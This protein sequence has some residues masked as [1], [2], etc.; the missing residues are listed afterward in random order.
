MWLHFTLLIMTS[1]LWHQNHSWHHK[2]TTAYT[3]LASHSLSHNIC[4]KHSC[5]SIPNEIKTNSEVLV[6]CLVIPLIRWN[7]QRVL[8]V[9][10]SHLSGDRPRSC[11]VTRSCFPKET[12]SS[13][14]ILTA[15]QP[16]IS[17]SKSGI[18]HSPPW[19]K[20]WADIWLGIVPS[21][22]RNKFSEGKT[23][24]RKPLD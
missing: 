21:I 12:K 22:I 10:L 17:Q 9:N 3:H 13:L 7:A 14:C 23:P 11:L 5:I 1:I 19:L 6:T 20:V 24:E 18:V 4:S 8:L 16:M 2:L 15:F